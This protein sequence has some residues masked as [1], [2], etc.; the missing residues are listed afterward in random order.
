MKH[1]IASDI[2]PPFGQYSHAVEIP[3]GARV[4]SIAGQVG[5]DANGHVPDS[6]SA[7]TELVF[8]NIERVLAAAGMTL[9]DLVKLNLFVVSR[10]D[11]PAIREVRNRILPTP[12]PA[13]S[14]MLVAGL[15]QES[16]RLEV[17]GIAARVD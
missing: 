12:P 16:W 3:P 10:E 13:M 15:G 4:L 1:L 7:Q 17:D 5:C 11:L 6:A 8:A 9:A 14:L 2:A